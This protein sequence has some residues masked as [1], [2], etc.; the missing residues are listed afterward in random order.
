MCGFVEEHEVGEVREQLHQSLA[1]YLAAGTGDLGHERKVLGQVR[2]ST[3]RCHAPAVGLERPGGKAQ[4]CRLAG[5][6]LADEGHAVAAVQPKVD[7]VEERRVGE[8]VPDAC[9]GE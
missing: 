8:V 6:V 1:L 2:D 7:V 5:A 3:A 9:E 4:Q